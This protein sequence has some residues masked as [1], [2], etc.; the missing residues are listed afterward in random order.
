MVEYTLAQE[1]AEEIEQAR[2][3][4]LEEFSDPHTA[5][6]LGA[7]GVG[8]GWR[9][10]DV[11]AGGG[12]ATRMLAERV[13]DAGSVLATDLDTRL[14]DRIADP[15]VEV[16]RHDLLSEPLPDAAFDL[17]HARNLLMHLPAR[18]DALRRMRA[19][20]RP[21]GW[22]ALLE[23]D[24]GSVALTP[25]DGAWR[26]VWSAFCD[27]AVAGGWDPCY[28]RR[29]RSDAHAVDL[30]DVHTEVFA[31]EVPGGAG[32]A[33]LFALSLQRFAERMVG[34]GAS[35]D[36]LQTVQRLLADPTVT[37]RSVTL[38]IAWGRRAA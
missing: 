15:R 11:G 4:L 1:G 38:T 18:V 26:R 25:T 33:R 19:A 36:D 3:S 35:N 6:Q 23:P 2:L 21:G 34:L 8:D 12:S 10:L 31:T 32:P 28:G 5:R 37:Y 24:F 17:V 9:C 16:R 7:I 22:L 20:V 13:G 29:L 14:L 27:A 30:V